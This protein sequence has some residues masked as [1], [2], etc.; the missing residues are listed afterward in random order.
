MQSFVISA[1]VWPQYQC[2]VMTPPPQLDPHL[3]G[4]GGPRGGKSYQ[5]KSHTQSYSIGGLK[6]TK[7]I[8]RATCVLNAYCCA[9]A[10]GVS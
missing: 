4:E 1:T 6:N 5:S 9:A 8:K 10:C 7:K 3:G 2:Q